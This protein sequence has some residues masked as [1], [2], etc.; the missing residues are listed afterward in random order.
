MNPVTARQWVSVFRDT[1]I[2][3]VAGFMAI[4]ETVFVSEPSV[5]ILA[6]AGTLFGVP[7]AL[8]LDSLVRKKPDGEGV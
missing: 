3:F 1:A 4:Y 5:Y 8:N 6:L 7:A 2:I